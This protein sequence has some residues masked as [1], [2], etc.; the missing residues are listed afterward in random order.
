MNNL[1]EALEICLQDIEQ[2]A[3]IETALFRYPDLADELRPILEA[4]VEARKMAVPPP[5]REV[6]G[7]H[8]AK[9][10]QQAAK[11]REAKARSSQRM[12]FVSLRRLAVTLAVLTILSVSGT[13]LVR[14]SSTTLPGDNL[15]PVKRTWEDVLVAFTFNIQQ[16]DALEIEHENERLQELQELFAEGRSAE[17]DFAGS[18]TKQNGNDWIV[19]NIPIMVSPQTEILGGPIVVGSAVRVKG[20][21]QSNNVVLAERI[22]LLPVGAKLPDVGDESESQIEKNEG[23]NSSTDDNSGK[24]SGEE[25]PKAGQT[26]TAEPESQHNGE[27]VTEGSN[28]NSN[29]ASTAESSSPE[30]GGN[31]NTSGDHSG[32]N[33]D[34]GHDGSNQNSHDGGGGD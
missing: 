6:V 21:T 14:A 33:I 4:S 31:D 20:Q 15:Y 29:D 9:V 28:N 23:S 12:W 16:R 34:G 18:V 24:G 27:S 3:D 25:A 10:L 17:V 2:G 5:S 7:R 19:S 30:I 11:M 26:Q 13:G 22:E 32:S 8:R 1:Y